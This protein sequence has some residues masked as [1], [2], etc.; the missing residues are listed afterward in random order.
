[1][2]KSSAHMAWTAISVCSATL[3]ILAGCSS[4]TSIP[5][6]PPVFAQQAGYMVR[7]Y[8]PRPTVSTGETTLDGSAVLYL[9]NFFGQSTASNAVTANDDGSITL[10][11]GGPTSGQVASASLAANADKFQGIAF[12]GG[13]YFEATLKFDGWQGQSSN[14]NSLS[15]GYPAFW[16]MAIEHLAQISTGADQWSGQASGYEHFSEVD[17]LEYDLAYLQKSDDVYGGSIH[18]FYGVFDQTCAPSDYCNIQNPYSTKIE[19]VPA[20]TDFSAYHTYGLLWVPATATAD[21]YIQ[22]YFDRTAVGQ[23]VTWAQFTNQTPPTTPADTDFG[24]VDLQ[25]L[26]VILGTGTQYPMTVSAISVWQKSADD[27]IAGH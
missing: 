17:F 25:H 2:D 16:S 10:L 21:G 5:D 24:I 19:K 23:P 13:A 14:P 22:W 1:M 9:W 4:S 8:G 12:G 26:V 6:L 15:R 11:G 27:D 3:L 18:D 20:D 7:T